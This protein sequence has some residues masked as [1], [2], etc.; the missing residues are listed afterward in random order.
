VA[1][2]E[3]RARLPD[4]C[5]VRVTGNPL[6]GRLVH[7][8][9]LDR[10]SAVSE[11]NRERTL[12]VLGGSG[13]AKTLNQH[14]PWALYKAGIGKPGIDTADD[15]RGGWRILHQS[16]ERDALATGELYR[17][18][19]LDA[20]VVPFIGDMRAALSEADL[21]VSRAGGTTLAEFAAF[22]VPAILLPYPHAADDHQRANADVFAAA[23]AC[24]VL[25]QR[26]L[27]DRLDNQLAA[28]VS[29]LAGDMALRSRMSEAM[30][31]QARPHAARLVVKAIANLLWP[32]LATGGKR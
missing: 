28:L 25:D 24:R 16:G 5:R 31:R 15:P 12:L 29:D 14:V 3:V 21:A 30:L 11:R 2:D 1:F 32:R 6:R 27:A 4:G 13:G 20:T 18:L 22:G 7:P 9:P 10:R 23:G 8:P 17:R 19:G 26:E